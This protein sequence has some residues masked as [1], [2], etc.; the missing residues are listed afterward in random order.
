[1]LSK[2]RP[3]NSLAGNVSNGVFFGLLFAVLVSRSPEFGEGRAK[4]R[5]VDPR[6][7]DQSR[8]DAPDAQNQNTT[9]AK[10]FPSF[11]FGRKRRSPVPAARG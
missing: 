5:R 3:K 4:G 9:S 8:R 10:H 1:M 6:L 7:G 11:C 2:Y